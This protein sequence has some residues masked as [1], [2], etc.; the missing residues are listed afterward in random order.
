MCPSNGGG[1]LCQVIGIQHNALSTAD[2]T[3]GAGRRLGGRVVR[4]CD[5]RGAASS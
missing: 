3:T 4:R 5:E 1:R 2:S